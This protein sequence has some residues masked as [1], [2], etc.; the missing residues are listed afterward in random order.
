MRERYQGFLSLVFV[1]FAL[2]LGG[3]GASSTAVTSATPALTPTATVV[4]VCAKLITPTV[5]VRGP[6]HNVTVLPSWQGVNYP[7][8]A[9][10]ISYANGASDGVLHSYGFEVVG[11]CADG[12]S[13]IGVQSFYSSDLPRNGWVQSATMPYK[14]D[15]NAACGDPYCWKRPA[16]S[17]TTEFLSLE[18]VRA[19]G[20]ATLFT[21]RHVLYSVNS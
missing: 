5:S 21:V 14:D 17:T 19:S 12:V 1:M 11:V 2:T 15:I 4:P 7:S 10:L 16:S 13:P 6:T 3:C 8:N 9:V 18:N 20:T